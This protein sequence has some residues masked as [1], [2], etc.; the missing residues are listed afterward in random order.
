MTQPTIE[1]APIHSGH[2][3]SRSLP[4]VD[5]VIPCYNYGHFLPGCV[6]SVLSQ[7]GVDVRILI[8]DDSSPDDS[9]AV[10]QH[11]ATQHEAVT[12]RRHD[13]NKGHIA[14]YNEGILDWSSSSYVVLL[15]AD[16]ML[17]PGALARA[18]SVMEDDPSVGMVYGRTVHFHDEAQ[19]ATVSAEPPGTRFTRYRGS[20]WLNKRLQAG[21][22]VITSPEVV[23]RGSVH[24]AVGGYR[25]ELPHS[26]DLEM[27]LRIAAI[28]DIAYL[29][30]VQA[31]Y[32]VHPSS[33]QRTKYKTSLLDIVHRKAA[34]D[35]FAQH[36]QHLPGIAEMQQ[37]V[38]R[39]LARES[40][41]DACRAY[42]HNR[43]S[44]ANVEEL[45][46]FATQAWPDYRRLPEYAALERRKRLGSTLCYRTQ[47]FIIP[48]SLRWIERKIKRTRMLREGI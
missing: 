23:V 9:A 15:S 24:K 26:G 32:R 27:W 34:F 44:E 45:V 38:N 4:T 18:V 1:L 25:K 7:L 10:G 42:D 46:T 5:V 22:N 3:V 43:L 30:H 17:A 19:L 21:N 6:N 31:Y 48:A 13:T 28:S 2:P 41:W 33:M 12:F 14:T 8:I 35:L 29:H 47:L 16:D 11:L 40:L 37:T 20:D 36:H 39:T